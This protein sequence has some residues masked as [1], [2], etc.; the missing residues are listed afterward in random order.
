[1]TGGSD[2]V[3]AYSSSH[4]GKLAKNTAADETVLTSKIISGTGGTKRGKP[5]IDDPETSI[6]SENLDLMPEREP[7]RKNSGG[8]QTLMEILNHDD[9]EVEKS[10]VEPMEYMEFPEERSAQKK[11]LESGV[12]EE[13][14][15]NGSD[16]ELQNETVEATGIGESEEKGGE[17]SRSSQLS[18]PDKDL[19][20]ELSQGHGQYEERESSG[21]E[22]EDRGNSA[23]C[24]KF[25][26]KGRTMLLPIP[27]KYRGTAF[28]EGPLKKRLDL[29]WV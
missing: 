7:L 17:R 2:K 8:D 14:E 25:A 29:R 15:D 20:H 28:N 19:D 9:E 5:E 23:Y 13:E 24:M 1:M 21:E 3:S 12:E 18:E 10:S 6:S 22:E 26:F 27:D 16:S 4:T 11:S